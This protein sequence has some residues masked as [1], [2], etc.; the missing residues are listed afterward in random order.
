MTKLPTNFL[1][2]LTYLQSFLRT[3]NASPCFVCIFS[4]VMSLIPISFSFF[5]FL[6]FPHYCHH[7][8]STAQMRFFVVQ[9]FRCSFHKISILCLLNLKEI[10]TFFVA[11]LFL[12][13][14]STQPYG[15]CIYILQIIL[16][17]IIIK[18]YINLHVWCVNFYII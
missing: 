12:F 2:L 17:I 10:S 15:V 1:M 4:T 7:S 14:A 6:F 3:S 5:F 9:Y 11:Q 16:S 13:L 8:L 18:N